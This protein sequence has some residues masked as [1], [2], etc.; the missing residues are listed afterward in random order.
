MLTRS[1]DALYPELGGA[2]GVREPVISV[3]EARMTSLVRERGER[4]LQGR[5][6]E[7]WRQRSRDRS[8]ERSERSR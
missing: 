7:E 4:P 5:A 1:I 8:T 2:R 3:R 6:L